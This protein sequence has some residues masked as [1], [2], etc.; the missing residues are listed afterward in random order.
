MPEPIQLPL[1]PETAALTRIRPECNEWRYYRLEV[2][3]DLF[4]RALLARHWGRIGTQGRMRL[5]PAADKVTMFELNRHLGWHLG[6]EGSFM[7][8]YMQSH[9]LRKAFLLCLS[10]ENGLKV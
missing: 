4:G 2:W 7:A 10:D 5:D 9:A 3:P 8:C 6:A 1:F